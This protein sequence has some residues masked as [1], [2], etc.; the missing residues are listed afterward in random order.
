MTERPCPFCGALLTRVNGGESLKWELP[1]PCPDA[2]PVRY[3]PIGPEERADLPTVG[4]TPHDPGGVA[5]GF[6]NLGQRIDALRKA[7]MQ[8]AS[9]DRLATS[10][11]DEMFRDVLKGLVARAES[12]NI[13]A[14]VE[15]IDPPPWPLRCIHGKTVVEHCDGCGKGRWQAAEVFPCRHGVPLSQP[16]FECDV[17]TLRTVT[18]DRCAWIAYA[19]GLEAAKQEARRHVM[20]RRHNVAIHNRKSGALEATITSDTGALVER[21]DGRELIGLIETDFTQP[22]TQSK[23]SEVLAAPEAPAAIPRES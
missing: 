14:P 7:L 8:S 13:M 11:R 17:E 19:H 6:F 2:G 4:L 20:E 16:C 5:C 12:L 10:A 3:S 22:V 9:E 1:A 21:E 23:R 18:C 15:P